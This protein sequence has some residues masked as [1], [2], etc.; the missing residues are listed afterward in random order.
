MNA[1]KFTSDQADL[2][3]FEAFIAGSIAH[4]REPD[5]SDCEGYLR[6][7]PGKSIRDWKGKSAGYLLG[8][9]HDQK[10]WQ[11]LKPGFV[12]DMATSR[13]ARDLP[14]N[15]RQAAAHDP[16]LVWNPLARKYRL[17]QPGDP[18]AA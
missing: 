18:R 13:L 17:R 8:R 2:A 1:N 15:V 14:H 5:R 9:E 4:L 11:S 6:A 16:E 12:R 7:Y 3:D 10:P